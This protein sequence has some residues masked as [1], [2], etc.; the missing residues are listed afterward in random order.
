MAEGN[1][2]M[3]LDQKVVQLLK[4]GKISP[5]AAAEMLKNNSHA[6]L[7][8]QIE[9]PN[10]IKEKAESNQFKKILWTLGI[11]SI[12]G[13]GGFFAYNSS[14]QKTQQST[15]QIQEETQEERDRNHN[16]YL[17]CE[18][19][20]RVE[21]MAS[22]KGMAMPK[23]GHLENEFAIF[24]PD[25]YALG[26]EE[27]CTRLFCVA[28]SGKYWESTT[29]DLNKH[30]NPSNVLAWNF[31]VFKDDDIIIA[32]NDEKIRVWPTIKG[33]N[34]TANDNV[35][36]VNLTNPNKPEE[37][38]SQETQIQEEKIDQKYTTNSY[39]SRGQWV[40]TGDLEIMV[41]DYRLVKETN[42]P[43]TGNGHYKRRDEYKLYVDL[44]LKNNVDGMFTIPLD[45]IYLAG[46]SE[47]QK[48][49]KPRGVENIPA[50]ANV[51]ETYSFW[52]TQFSEQVVTVTCPKLG[53]DGD[54]GWFKN[55]G[56]AC[57]N[58]EKLPKMELGEPY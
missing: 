23:Y 22:Q 13:S 46:V 45:E 25:T 3:S 58:L 54:N 48:A 17:S 9:T 20:Q 15:Q 44:S 42:Y 40:N 53:R 18:L 11:I 31:Y 1:N 6:D 27:I 55:E 16:R 47:R 38:N 43:G 4:D 50:M 12:L 32:G 57:I 52:V 39:G 7:P 24:S 26:P 35:A 51:N 10:Q 33:I 41:T 14:Q 36:F 29:L 8:A 56:K 37:E 2:E 28:K 19:L 34:I 5:E 49:E 21:R 30:H